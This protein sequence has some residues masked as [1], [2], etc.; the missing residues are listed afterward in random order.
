MQTRYDDGV[1][2]LLY[3]QLHINLHEKVYSAIPSEIDGKLYK[4]MD[5]ASR[6][7]PL[8]NIYD[9]K[10]GIIEEKLKFSIVFP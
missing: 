5:C 4:W 3:I 7:T 9:R 10:K 2:C 1:K 6:K 8:D